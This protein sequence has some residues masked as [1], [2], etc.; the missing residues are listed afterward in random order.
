MAIFILIKNKYEHSRHETR[1]GNR[2]NTHLDEPNRTHQHR[3][4][5]RCCCSCSCCCSFAHC[6]KKYTHANTATTIKRKQA[7]PVGDLQYDEAWIHS[8]IIEGENNIINSV[9]S[10]IS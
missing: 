2:A 7:E 8:Y 5:F 3:V 6:I 1:T 10:L 4:V 9:N